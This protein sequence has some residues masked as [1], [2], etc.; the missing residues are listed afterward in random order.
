[1]HIQ[2]LI[3]REILDSRGW[4]TVEVDVILDNGIMGRAAVP[5]GASTGSREALE[6]RDG[7]K[8]RYLGRGVQKCVHNII[9][10]IQPA[11]LGFPVVDQAAI[12]A[13]LVKLDGSPIKSN[14]G[15]NSLLAVSL[16]CARARAEVLEVP[17][18]AS[19][20]TEVPPCLPV[21][22]L[23]VLNGGQHADNGL[24]IQEFMIL[25]V[26]APTFKE[27]M[28]YGVEV[29]QSLKSVLKK[30]GLSTAVGDEGGFAPH[31]PSHEAAIE[32]LLAA[33]EQAGLKTGKDITLALDCAASE[34]YQN[35]VYQLGK[36]SLSAEQWVN[37][38][39][40]WAKQY[41]IYSIEDG[42]A[43]EDWRGWQHLYETIGE[44]VQLVGDD[45]L[46]TQKAFVE[47]AMHPQ[48]CN[49]VLLKPN[50]VGTLTETL[51]TLALARQYGWNA[52]FS[53][54]SGETE[55]S[56]LADLAVGTGVGHIKTGAPCRS[57]RV[58]KYNQLLRI[59]QADPSLGYQGPRIQW[60]KF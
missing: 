22:Y 37:R 28:R 21:P 52:V 42:M 20:Q 10:L 34:F 17:L 35:G 3:A 8:T 31:L 48:L 11:L 49:A 58:A 15:A 14:L 23:N 46:V 4:P 59:E 40:G 45:L 30:S 33:I 12:D 13:L 18:Y 6:L 47:K 43:E 38:L 9:E 57:E 56:F 7:D 29:Y 1:M 53:H 16:A 5:S 50:Q 32:Q 39:A 24:D 27:A 36:E 51:E 60:Q 44:R 25:P 19:L 41:P 55:D 2:Q 54:R 26:G